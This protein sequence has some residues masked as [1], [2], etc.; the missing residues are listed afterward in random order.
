MKID[1]KKLKQHSKENFSATLSPEEKRTIMLERDYFRRMNTAIIMILIIATI[2]VVSI[3]LH[4]IP[5][6]QQ[7]AVTTQLPPSQSWDQ[8]EPDVATVSTLDSLYK[9]V[10]L[11]KQV[12]LKQED[13]LMQEEDMQPTVKAKSED[14]TE[15]LEVNDLEE[16]L[17]DLSELMNLAKGQSNTIATKEISATAL[18]DLIDWSSS[19][20]ATT[21][22]TQILGTSKA[23][24]H[25][26]SAGDA[27]E[28]TADTAG[29]RVFFAITA[30]PSA[31]NTQWQQALGEYGDIPGMQ[32]AL[33]IAG[34]PGYKVKVWELDQTGKVIN[35]QLVDLSPEDVDFDQ[36]GAVTAQRISENYCYG[37]SVQA[38]SG[39][40]SS[41]L[42]YEKDPEQELILVPLVSSDTEAVTIVIEI[43]FEQEEAQIITDGLE[44]AEVCVDE[45]ENLEAS[46]AEQAGET[47][48]VSLELVSFLPLE[49][50]LGIAEE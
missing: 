14:E 7:V 27:W 20:L 30:N 13:V 26:N 41:N 34:D 40:H 24:V 3:G 44:Q 48:V 22:L 49:N 36:L 16:G 18:I 47:A 15:K 45:A 12:V 31:T 46:E 42:N 17:F 28:I 23:F 9:Q 25:S 32:L 38:E 29:Q 39:W 6:P 19:G 50:V 10:V 11:N 21:H 33:N 8:E 4:F 35:S 37:N 43:I 5:Q 1:K 2:A